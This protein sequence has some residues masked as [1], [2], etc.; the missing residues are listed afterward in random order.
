M[1]SRAAIY[2]NLG[3]IVG[4]M[5]FGYIRCLLTSLLDSRNLLTAFPVNIPVD[6]SR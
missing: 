4:G 1:A 3:A 5:F 2:S 6:V